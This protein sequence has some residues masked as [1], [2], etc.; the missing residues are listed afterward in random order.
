MLH[1]GLGPAPKQ[2]LKQTKKQD[3]KSPGP[4]KTTQY[5]LFGFL[6]CGIVVD[7]GVKGTTILSL[8]VMTD[9]LVLKFS[10]L[11]PFSSSLLPA[12]VNLAKLYDE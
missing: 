11:S 5:Y 8:L 4:K 1:Q 6:Q 2:Y 12:Y 7:R 3:P 10:L 9:R